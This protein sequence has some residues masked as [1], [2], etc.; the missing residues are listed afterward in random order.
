M[1]VSAPYY[2]FMS[3]SSDCHYQIV[4]KSQVGAGVAVKIEHAVYQSAKQFGRHFNEYDE[5]ISQI[6]RASIDILKVCSCPQAP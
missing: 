6:T 3:Y 2:L 4:K 1:D 5:V